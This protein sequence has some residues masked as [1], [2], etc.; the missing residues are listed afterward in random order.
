MEFAPNTAV[1]PDDLRARSRAFALDVI[2]LCASLQGDDLVRVIRPQLL[3]SA[4]G[5][6]ANYR[7]T[8]RARSG[9]E[10]AS[11]L[12]VVVEEADEAEFWIDILLTE[13]C[14]PAAQL[15]ALGAEA[16]ELRAI[17]SASRKTV[18]ERLKRANPGD[19]KAR[20][21]NANP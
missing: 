4:T 7:A 20:T 17:F 2:R 1:T 18:L 8:C 6:A 15:Q 5:V 10:F 3:R 21:P 19:A 12:A 14:G 16:V 13:R 11:R 9:R